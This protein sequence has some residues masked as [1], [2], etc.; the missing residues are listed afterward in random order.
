MVNVDGE[1][2]EAKLATAY[3]QGSA[4]HVSEKRRELLHRRCVGVIGSPDELADRFFAMVE[5][6]LAK[7]A[8]GTPVIADNVHVVADGAPWIENLV[9]DVLPGAS[10]TLDWYHVVE[11]VSDAV[12]AAYDDTKQQRRFRTKW[13][14]QLRRG[15]TDE[16][17]RSLVRLMMRLEAGTSAQEAVTALHRYLNERRHLLNY[18]QMRV[19]GLP[20]GSGVA[21]SA[22]K[23]VLQQRMKRP[24]MRWKSS[25]AASMVALRCA[26]RSTGG[27]DALFARMHRKAA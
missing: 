23:H 7:T 12:R 4:V 6:Y 22:I 17:L 25:G 11:H 16:M 13:L 3:P 2:R 9:N 1:W 26:Y 20:I 24:G 18:P 14:N 5:P 27:F 8:D 15:Q 19:A 10:M 21:E